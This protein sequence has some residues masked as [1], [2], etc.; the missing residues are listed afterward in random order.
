MRKILL[1]IL[2]IFLITGCKVE[3]NLTIND[4]LTVLESVSMTG[5]DEFFDSFYKSSRINVVNMML[6]DGRKEELKNNNYTYN[7]I[8]GDTPLVVAKKEYASITNFC[9]KTLFI[10]QYFDKINVTD[11]NGIVSLTSGKFIPINEDSNEQYAIKESVIKI[12]LPYLV[13]ENNATSFD[14]NTNTYQWNIYDD[15]NE[16]SILLNYDTNKVYEIPKDSSNWIMIIV[17]LLFVVVLCTIAYIMN[18]NNK[19]KV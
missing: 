5:T 11:N 1:L 3:Y 19:L 18:K 2:C 10:N 14:P 13:L 12:K 4:D 9:D 8:D 15:T 17:T 7:I 6:E 16:F